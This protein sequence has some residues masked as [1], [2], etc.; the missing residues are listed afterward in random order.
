M[1][2]R[3][4]QKEKKAGEDDD[5]LSAGEGAVRQAGPRSP[6]GR[7]EPHPL[8][9]APSSGADLSGHVTEPSGSWGRRARRT[10]TAA[11]PGGARA[12]QAGEGRAPGA[13]GSRRARPLPA[14][15]GAY[16]RSSHRP[17]LRAGTPGG[18]RVDMASDAL[19][20]GAPASSA[21]W[22]PAGAG[23]PRPRAAGAPG[24]GAARTGP[25][26]PRAL[27][28]PSLGRHRGASTVPFSAGG[29]THKG[30]AGRS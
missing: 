20:V 27:G 25:P 4:I 19:Q 21:P 26:L 1:G 5:A 17:S 2:R 18:R 10:D 8:G 9:P 15:R 13:G 29:G 3:R 16:A 12:E 6:G 23:D 11:R 22:R 28:A 7:R 14:P 30:G 24:I